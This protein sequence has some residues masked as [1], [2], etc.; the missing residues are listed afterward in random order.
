MLQQDMSFVLKQ[1]RRSVHA[2]TQPSLAAA[3]RLRLALRLKHD[4]QDPTTE[5]HRFWCEN[6]QY[7]SS[8]HTTSGSYQRT[9]R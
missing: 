5:N 9:F 2:H 1:T 8:I 4:R 3:C 6:W 7:E